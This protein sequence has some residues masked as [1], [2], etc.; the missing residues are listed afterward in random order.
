MLRPVLPGSKEMN[1]S[2]RPFRP[3]AKNPAKKEQLEEERPTQDQEPE[4]YLLQIDRQ[5]KRSFKTREAAQSMGLELKGRFP[6]L[7]VSIFDNVSK[8]RTVVDVPK[9]A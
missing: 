5:T 9:T 2:Q 7:Q 1:V 8:S 4:R 3:S 6:A